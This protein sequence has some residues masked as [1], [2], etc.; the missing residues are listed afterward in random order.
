M[1]RIEKYEVDTHPAALHICDGA[2]GQGD[3]GDFMRCVM[4]MQICSSKA[5]I[6][7]TRLKVTQQYEL[8]YHVG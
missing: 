5:S 6:Y 1:T 2:V 4:E 3:P 7:N 8:V